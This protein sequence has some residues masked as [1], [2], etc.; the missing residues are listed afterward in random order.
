MYKLIPK[1]IA[2]IFLSG[3]FALIGCGGTGTTDKD[4]VV[5]SNVIYTIGDSYT[6]TFQDLDEYARRQGV[7]FRYD[8][9]LYGYTEIMK[10]LVGNQYKRFDFFERKL[11]EN[12]EIMRPMQRYINEELGAAWYEH[13]FLGKYLTDEYLRAS[14]E[15]MKYE[16]MYRQIVLSDD[17]TSDYGE[18][19]IESKVLQ[20]ADR[21]EKGEDFSSL[22][23]LYSQEPGSRRNGGNAPPAT[24]SSSFENPVDSAV[25]K[26]SPGDVKVVTHNNVN[27]I[28][29]I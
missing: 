21:L 5:D 19:T 27:Y 13:S 24:W 9:A 18:E 6:L 11:H 4:L 16:V 25:R 8:D 3:F 2:F 20:I 26:L 28:V 22:M 17:D 14:Y 29:Q 15:K 10:E 7:H 23:N 12:Q 1:Y